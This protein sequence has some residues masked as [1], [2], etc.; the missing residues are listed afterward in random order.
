MYFL[1]GTSSTFR[2]TCLEWWE[3]GR[4]EDGG[5]EVEVGEIDDSL[6]DSNLGVW[7]PHNQFLLGVIG[8]YNQPNEGDSD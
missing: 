1:M 5:M 4:G 6:I 8:P 7:G 2:R 3:M